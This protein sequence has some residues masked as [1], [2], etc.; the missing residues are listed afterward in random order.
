[1]KLILSIRAIS[2]QVLQANN[3]GYFSGIYLLHHLAHLFTHKEFMGAQ[4]TDFATHGGLASFWIFGS[5]GIVFCSLNAPF[6]VRIPTE[7][8]E[9]HLVT[10]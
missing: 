10:I 4:A 3:H 5:L 8:T 6:K 9:Y 1:M 2:F 7:G